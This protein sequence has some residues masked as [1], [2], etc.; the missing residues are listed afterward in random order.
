MGFSLTP[1]TGSRDGPSGGFLDELEEDAPRGSRVN[2]GH[3]AT[4]GA[5]PRFL[6]H[7]FEPLLSQAAHLRPDVGDRESDMMQPLPVARDESG[8][9]RVGREGVEKFD[10]GAAGPEGG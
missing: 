1:L 10:R 7:K 9:D 8:D 3:E 4:V 5:R 2:E 6:V